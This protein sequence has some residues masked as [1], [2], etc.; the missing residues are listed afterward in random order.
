MHGRSRSP[1]RI[2]HD[3]RQAPSRDRRG[4]HDED[5][6]PES[7]DKQKDRKHKKDKKKSKKH[8]KHKHHDKDPSNDVNLLID[9][10]EDQEQHAIEEMRKRRN[11]ILATFTGVENTAET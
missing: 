6:R 8:K 3:R 7:K 9:G 1:R 11:E 2:D 5:R 4:V 10:D